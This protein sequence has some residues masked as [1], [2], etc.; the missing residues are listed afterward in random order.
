MGYINP[1]FSHSLELFNHFII[2][3]YKTAPN[4]QSTLSQFLITITSSFN[5][6]TLG[7]QIDC[8]NVNVNCTSG[9]FQS[10]R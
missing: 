5:H 8:K 2:W 6:F 4:V 10:T 3:K 7:N 1:Y 9:I